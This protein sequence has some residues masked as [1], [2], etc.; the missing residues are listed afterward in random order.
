MRFAK[1]LDLD[2]IQRL[3]KSHEVL[4]TV[5]EGSIGGFGS[6]VVHHLANLGLMDRGLK[7]RA[8]TLPD[9]FQD[10]A[11]QYEQYE[12]AQLNARHI[13]AKALEA[14]GHEE[15]AVQAAVRA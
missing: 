13:V 11:T 15:A 2:M 10:Q 1:P 14:L 9:M 4:I 8:M 3:A 7:I 5:E 6:H 12:Q